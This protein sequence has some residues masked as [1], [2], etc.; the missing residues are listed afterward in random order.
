VWGTATPV[1]NYVR[2][3]KV[4]DNDNETPRQQTLTMTRSLIVVVVMCV[5]GGGGVS[6][7][8]GKRKSTTRQGKVG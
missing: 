6:C 5:C 2:C 8:R 3:D 7:K 4:Q 1:E